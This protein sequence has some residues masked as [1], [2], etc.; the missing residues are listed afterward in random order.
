M[1]MAVPNDGRRALD[2]EFD[3]SVAPD[4]VGSALAQQ[5]VPESAPVW[6]SANGC[7]RNH[8]GRSTGSAAPAAVRRKRTALRTVAPAG[9]TECACI[10]PFMIW[11]REIGELCMG[12]LLGATQPSKTTQGR[13]LRS[14]CSPKFVFLP[15]HGYYT[16][17]V[18]WARA[19]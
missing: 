15:H 18:T 3:A 10:R 6:G 17:S 2:P 7:Y 12:A 16:H 5:P 19:L 4:L 13:S 11:K 9:G 14:F 8:S 1:E